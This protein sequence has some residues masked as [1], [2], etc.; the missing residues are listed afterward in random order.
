MKSTFTTLL[1]IS[2]WKTVKNIDFDKGFP[3]RMK[4]V[5]CNDLKVKPF[6]P[7]EGSILPPPPPH[8]FFCDNSKKAP[9]SG[10][11]N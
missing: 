6:W 7:G 8:S 9:F 11:S 10:F 2:L 4:L 5:G 1:K 3:H